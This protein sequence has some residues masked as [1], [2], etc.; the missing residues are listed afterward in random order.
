MKV[1]IAGMR[2]YVPYRKDGQ[3]IA[4]MLLSLG[5]T[6]VVSG[7][8]KGADAYGE[9]IAQ[10]MEIP[11]KIFPAQ[12]STFGKSAGPRR[13]REMAIYAD[14]LIAVW[15]NMSKGTFNMISQARTQ[16]LDVH[17]ISVER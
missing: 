8:A 13:N 11:V 15:D 3:L 5:C 2:D 6:E 12:W 1:I 7:G 4:E 9:S 14:A 16:G 10:Y 17:I